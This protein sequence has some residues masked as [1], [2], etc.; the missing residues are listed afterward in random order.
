M[1]EW[2][3]I[4]QR[5]SGVLECW[6]VGF[7]AFFITPLLQFSSTPFLLPPHRLHLFSRDAAHFLVIEHVFAFLVFRG[8][9]D[10]LRRVREVTA[11]QVRGRIR[12]FPG[13]VVQNLVAEL[14]Q[15]VA[16]AENDVVRAGHPN[17][18]V[19]LEH[20]LT[21][22][23]PFGVELV[24]QFRSARDV[25]IPF[26]HLDHLAR[27]AGDAAIGPA[28]AQKLRP[29]RQ[30]IR[31][32]GKDGVEPALGIFGGDGVEQ[33]EAVAVVK[34]EKWG[35][36][37]EDKLWHRPPVCGFGLWHRHLVCGFGTQAGG[38]CHNGAIL[39]QFEMRRGDGMGM[40]QIGNV[41]P[42][43]CRQN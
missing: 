2:W 9:Q 13:D 19:R 41:L 6:S 12:L 25:P 20:A 16:D 37:G 35:F 42:A 33:F 29:G 43:S 30:E 10:G 34:A 24:V 22:S 17:R 27:V 23:Q 28:F 32:I 39:A 1:L 18:A 3:S 38:L 8:P 40:G 4:G 11:T 7:G 5:S 21:P 15:G 26:I 14:L 31:R 36:G